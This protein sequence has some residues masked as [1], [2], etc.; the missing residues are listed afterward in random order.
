MNLKRTILTVSAACLMLTG[1]PSQNVDAA[2]ATTVGVG[3]SEY[4]TAKGDTTRA[5]EASKLFGI[6]ATD[7]RTLKPG[8]NSQLAQQAGRDVVNFLTAAE[9]GNQTIAQIDVALN[10]VLG[11]ITDLG[12]PEPAGITPAIHAR[13]V[14]SSPAPRTVAEFKAQFNAAIAQNPVAGEKPLK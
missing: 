12:A 3:V 8:T 6:L 1:C 14:Q 4:L 11:I 2:I 13:A 9:P 10:A 7:I 5:N